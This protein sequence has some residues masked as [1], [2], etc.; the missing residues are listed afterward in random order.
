[1]LEMH[2][3]PEQWEQFCRQHGV[4]MEPHGDEREDGYVNA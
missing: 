4:D 1:M 3:E 2:R